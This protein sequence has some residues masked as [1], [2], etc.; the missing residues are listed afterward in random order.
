MALPCRIILY[1]RALL[2]Y[3]EVYRVWQNQTKPS[4]AL[5]HRNVSHELKINC[6]QANEF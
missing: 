4:L 2:P 5:T 1:P 3:N 6:V